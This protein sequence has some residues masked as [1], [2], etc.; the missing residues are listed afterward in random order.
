[1]AKTVVVAVRDR[2]ID[3]FSRPFFVPSIGAAIRSFR[4]EVNNADSPMYAHPEDYDLYEL[5]WFEDSSGTF[6]SD[7]PRQVAIGKDC[8][9]PLDKGVSGA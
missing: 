2:A 3:S 8:K 7:G 9:I 6:G 1:M 4:D 5:G